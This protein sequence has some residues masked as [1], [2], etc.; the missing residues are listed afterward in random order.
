MA[1]TVARRSAGPQGW[2]WAREG[3]AR[4]QRMYGVGLLVSFLPE[5]AASLPLLRVH[6]AGLR[7]VACCVVLVNRLEDEHP[8][9][10][11]NANRSIAVV[12]DYIAGQLHPQCH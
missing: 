2:D 1:P 10:L 4:P 8:K 7:A 11:V 3:G 12:A 9:E 6:R 5:K